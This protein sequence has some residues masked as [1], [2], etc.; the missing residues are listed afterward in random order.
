MQPRVYTCTPI[1]MSTM[2]T[3]QPIFRNK[4]DN[5]KWEN[6]YNILQ[7]EE[8]TYVECNVPPVRQKSGKVFLYRALDALKEVSL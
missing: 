7:A 4:R 1:A 5:L 2:I 6:A 8:G 3:A